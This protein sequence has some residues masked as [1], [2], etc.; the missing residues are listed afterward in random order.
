MIIKRE[1]LGSLIERLMSKSFKESRMNPR[2]L[3]SKRTEREVSRQS[4]RKF[5]E[6]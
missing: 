2:A 5:S 3:L 4:R 1:K 6:K